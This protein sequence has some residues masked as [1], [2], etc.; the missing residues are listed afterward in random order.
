MV[1]TSV[2][3][4]QIV[5]WS[6]LNTVK[7]RNQ[8]STFLIEGEHVIE[9][10]YKAKLIEKLICLE[11][12]VPLYNEYPVMYV[13]SSVM[14]KIS[15][16]TSLSKH[17][18]LCRFM[19]NDR[20]LSD[21][22]VILDR[23]QNPSNVGAI[24]RTALALGFDSIILS[25]DSVDIYNEKLISASQGA[26]FHM[27][28][29][30]EALDE[31]ILILKENGYVIL[32]TDLNADNLINDVIIPEK[33]GVVFGNEGVGIQKEILNISNISFKIPISNINSLSVLSSASICLFYFDHQS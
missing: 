2:S 19:D 21:R 15:K 25:K 1:I 33:Y 32:A 28:V 27:K 13:N 6:K 31:Y 12:Q 5:Q 30:V 11:E 22:I 8:T 24:I 29:K 14:K 10:A 23:V 9:E 4:P 16:N 26:L 3:N 17:M 7:Y 20:E 18:A